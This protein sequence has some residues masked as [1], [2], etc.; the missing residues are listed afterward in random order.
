MRFLATL[1]ALSLHLLAS[2]AP[3]RRAT[4]AQDLTVLQFAF[5]LE[6]LETQFYQQA[7]QKYQPQDFTNAGYSSADVAVEQLKQIQSDEATHTSVLQSTIT[8]AGG[9]PLTSCKFDFT[10]AL[11]DVSTTMAVARVVEMVGVGAYLGAA[12][13]VQDPQLLTA[14]ASILTVEARHQTMLNILGG[15]TTAIP[16]AFDLPLKPE[17]VLAIAS[18][19]IS[20]CD[21]GIKA[22]T[23]L[24]IT[25]K[26]TPK[27]GTTLTFDMSGAQ[28]LDAS[29]LSCQ[30]LPG[31]A[32]FAVVQ[33]MNNCVVPAINGPVAIFITNDTQPLLNNQ[34]QFGG[35]IVMGPTLAFIDQKAETIGQLVRNTGTPVVSTNV[36]SPAD[37]SSIQSAAGAQQTGGANKQAI[38]G[39]PNFATGPSPD[40]HT[41]VQGWTNLPGGVNPPS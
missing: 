18:P 34:N 15:S 12:S 31:G 9:T 4:S 25:N 40:G 24:K 10:S 14:A 19:F 33:P 7:I 20:G 37:A 39:G 13:L 6:Q 5:V 36:V 2:A 28:G 23:P 41:I 16:G 38:P 8:S 29:K 11:T 26:D 27:V 3:L 1:L 17:Q 21:L 22:N 35:E 30:M 32:P